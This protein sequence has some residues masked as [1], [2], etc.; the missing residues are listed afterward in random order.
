MHKLSRT[1]LLYM[2]PVQP[3]TLRYISQVH[4]PLCCTSSVHSFLSITYLQYNPSSPLRA[5]STSSSSRLHVCS[6][7]P[8]LRY[9][10]PVHP[11][12]F[13]YRSS[14]HPPSPPFCISSTPP[15]P[16]LHVS[17]K[18][19][20]L[21]Y[22]TSPVLPPKHTPLHSLPDF[23]PGLQDCFSSPQL[24]AWTLP[25]PSGISYHTHIACTG[26]LDQCALWLTWQQRYYFFRECQGSTSS[27]I[28]STPCRNPPHENPYLKPFLDPFYS[29][30]RCILC[31]YVSL[32]RNDMS[33]YAAYILMSM[34]KLLAMQVCIIFAS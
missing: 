3:P 6:T 8:P 20:P 9:V 17:N 12:P 10:S 25:T 21:L 30:V 26:Y 23:H 29:A 7:P 1:F 22:Y 32:V 16:P 5:S 14:V 19:T 15:S 28:Q 18:Q 13:C 24:M 4:P 34:K 2:S 11:S 33:C 31:S 27:V